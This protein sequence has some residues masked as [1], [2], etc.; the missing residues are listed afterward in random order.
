M[1]AGVTG[2]LG[3]STSVGKSVSLMLGQWPGAG[4]VGLV[5]VVASVV[6]W[7]VPEIT[8]VLARRA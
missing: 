3:R 2:R 5:D 8:C 4:P 7:E 1:G 6:G